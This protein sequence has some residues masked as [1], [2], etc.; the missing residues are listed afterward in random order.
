MPS[1]WHWG[2]IRL[3]TS[4]E[5]QPVP[6]VW[7]GLVGVR[8]L[9]EGRL[10]PLLI[11]DTTKRSDIDDM[12]RAHHH[13]GP[14]DATSVW[15]RPSRW[16]EDRVGLVITT[17]K[18]TRC[19]IVIE[20]DLDTWGGTVDKIVEKQAVYI[21]PGR[22]GDRLVTTM[23]HG[24][25]LVEIPTREFRQNWDHMFR[26]ATIA[27]LRR[28]GLNRTQA[29]QAAAQFMETWRQALSHRMRSD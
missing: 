23:D 11:L 26:K 15:M 25:L 3:Q 18:P 7:D 12:I 16:T 24:R 27:K 2:E 19:T 13:L 8:G 5:A 17:I 28:R 20:F 10:I 14:G 21:Q 1:K 6:I 4:D 22:P 29:K 9:G